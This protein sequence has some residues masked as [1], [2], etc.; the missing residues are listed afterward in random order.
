MAE[1][2]KI[3]AESFIEL[4][5]AIGYVGAALFEGIKAGIKEY[6][7][8]AAAM[9]VE[10]QTEAKNSTEP[11]RKTRIADCIR[12]WCDTCGGLEGC[13]AR[14]GN[15]SYAASP[16]YGCGDGMRY[17]PIEEECCEDFAPGGAPNHG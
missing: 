4:G 3:D 6:E 8:T 17:K 1:S 15:D 16:C 14:G 9:D 5:R 11:P 12:C 10:A 7:L 13:R 2:S